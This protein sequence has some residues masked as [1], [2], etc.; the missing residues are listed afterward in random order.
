MNPGALF[1][2][3]TDPRSSGRPAEA[4]RIAAGVGVWK[5]IDVAV[6]LR[7]AAI[8][9]LGENTDELVDQDNFT[10]YSAAPGRI[11]PPDLCPGRRPV[12][13]AARSKRA[14][15]PGNFRWRAG[16][17]GGGA[18]AGHAFLAMP[19]VLHILTRPDD[20]LAREIIARQSEK[21]RGRNRD[22]GFDKAAAR[23]RAIARKNIRGRFRGE[24]VRN[25]SNNSNSFRIWRA[26]A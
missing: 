26:V 23:L 6:Y 9:I 19:R 2:I 16:A 3:D 24:L 18:V 5:R 11:G 10:R 21:Q 25:A 14:A 12:A 22:C 7:D 15:I 4:V 1:V 8:L 17:I 13:G 20:A